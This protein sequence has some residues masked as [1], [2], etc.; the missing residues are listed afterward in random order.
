MLLHFPLNHIFSTN[1]KFD[2]LRCLF[3]IF[4]WRLLF[5]NC[6]N[7]YTGPKLHLWVSKNMSNVKFRSKW[8]VSNS[9]QCINKNNFRNHFWTWGLRRRIW[10][11]IDWSKRLLKPW[12][13]SC[14]VLK[15]CGKA[16]VFQLAAMSLPWVGLNLPPSSRFAAQGT[17]TLPFPTWWAVGWV[18]WVNSHLLFLKEFINLSYV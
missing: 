15:K 16:A 6:W 3:V 7:E 5:I 12:H 1:R 4:P 10:V 17:D 9:I 11:S 18:L 14:D 13:R 8:I 2:L